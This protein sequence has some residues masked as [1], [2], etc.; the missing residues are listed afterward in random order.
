M[1]DPQR[2]TPDR[3]PRRGRRPSLPL[4][5][6]VVVALLAL[7]AGLGWY[8]H[9]EDGGI[10]S[11]PSPLYRVRRG[12]LRISLLE[13]GSIKAAR[14]ENIKSQVPGNL[15]I[16]YIVPEGAVI[17]KE[18][19]K[20]KKILVEL[21]SSELK[22]RLNQQE[23]TVQGSRANLT[24]ARESH[25]IQVSENE[26]SIQKGELD[27]K[28]ALMELDRHLG[29]A[30]TEE[31][32]KAYNAG[33]LDLHP[34]VRDARLGGAALQQLRKKQA[35][36]DLAREEL[37]RAM[38][39][40]DWTERLYKAKQ[41]SRNDVEADKLAVKRKQNSLREAETDY[42]LHLKYDFPKGTEK[43]LSD[44]REKRRGLER[45]KAKAR[46][47]LAKVEAN[48]LAKEASYLL[49]KRRL[50]EYRKNV[51]D[52]VIRATKPG[53]VVYAS[54]VASPWRRR[55]RDPIQEGTM[56]R[57][58]QKIITMP[59]VSEMMVEVKVHESY[60]DRVR[61]GLPCLISTDAFPDLVLRGEVAR[62]ADLPDSQA[63]WL[64]PD[65]KV[66][67]TDV[68]I[69]G[70]HSKRLKPGVSAKVEIT[71][72]DLKDVVYVPLQ[73]VVPYKEEGR[74]VYVQTEEGPKLRKVETGL[75]NNT[76]IEIEAG[77][78]QG[79]FVLLS[80]PQGPPPG[81]NAVRKRPDP[82][83]AP[84]EPKRPSAEANGTSAD[85][86]EPEGAGT[87]VRKKAPGRDASGKRPRQGKRT[88]AGG[89]RKVSRPASGAVRG[90]SGR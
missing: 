36:I 86:P 55:N 85:E 3:K 26:S 88:P 25:R 68:R 51:A 2:T 66:Y 39:T 18:D 11:S 23:V 20:N 82:N 50:D 37:Q 69:F 5:L 31:T 74:A 75:F 89:R 56:V 80:P 35:D 13:G 52:C 19:V 30:L 22:D 8:A 63:Y 49:Q 47:E 34:L 81:M 58:R 61:K 17:T 87:R 24:Q 57:Q 83:K 28:F 64:N 62:V 38:D 27:H 40:L 4:V 41:V 70:D 1:P 33:K 79:E 45:I 84:P 60:A 73:A 9:R 53:L 67:S 77:L 90:G 59:D 16:I 21:D 48:M 54:S 29:V 71:I 78:K 6:A 14:S 44:V 46:S 10:M 12:D 65:L 32:L 7:A 43:L 42:Q 76:A 15:R 72:K